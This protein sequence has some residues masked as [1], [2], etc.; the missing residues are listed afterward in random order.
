MGSFISSSLTSIMASWMLLVGWL[1]ASA[2]CMEGLHFSLFTFTWAIS[3]LFEVYLHIHQTWQSQ[4]TALLYAFFSFFVFL[5]FREIIY[6]FILS[7]AHA[8]FQPFCCSL[9]AG[10]AAQT[11][12]QCYQRQEGSAR[13]GYSGC[14]A[15]LLKC[16]CSY[17]SSSLML[18][19]RLR[20]SCLAETALH[21]G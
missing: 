19:T 2:T 13:R 7:C 15:R 11:H 4:T 20:S 6:A 21:W 14:A 1:L 3:Y 8:N 9:D 17:S 10:G 5:Q 12:M 16:H 18:C